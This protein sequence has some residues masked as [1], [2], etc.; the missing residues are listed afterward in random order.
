MKLSFSLMTVTFLIMLPGILSLLVVSALIYY[1]GTI[2]KHEKIAMYGHILAYSL[3]Q[4]ANAVLMGKPDQ[5]ISTRT[6]LALRSG[7]AK[8]FVKPFGKF[9]DYL[10]LVIAGDRNH[11]EKSPVDHTGDIELWHW[12]KE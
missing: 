6:A 12:T 11:I 2:W 5:T 8:W 10:A 7:K 1:A 9:V 4:L 3:D